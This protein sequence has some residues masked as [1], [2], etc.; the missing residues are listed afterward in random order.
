[1]I[2]LL[3]IEFARTF[4]H[5]ASKLHRHND[6]KTCHVGEKQGSTIISEETINPL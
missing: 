2:L 3:Q 1:M 6:I 4:K 5:N